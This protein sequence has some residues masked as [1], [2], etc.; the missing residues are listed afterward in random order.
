MKKR[1]L[2]LIGII[3]FAQ[4]VLGQNT[5]SIKGKVVNKQNNEPVPFANIVIWGTNIGSSSDF[6]GN[7]VFAGLEP[8]FI[9]LRA[10]AVGFKPYVASSVQ[11]TNARSVFIEIELEETAVEIEGVVIT[12]SPFRRSEESP[13]S[14]SALGLTKLR[15]TQVEIAT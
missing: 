11:I 5:G 2:V 3:A 10:S 12:A 6:D 9:E 13:V 14:F 15:K 7:F 1:L 8:G 4:V